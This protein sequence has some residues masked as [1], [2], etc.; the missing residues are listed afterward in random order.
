[1]PLHENVIVAASSL[2][3][4]QGRTGGC[5]VLL[6][7]VAWVDGGQHGQLHRLSCCRPLH[8]SST[9]LQQARMQPECMAQA[10]ARKD[11]YVHMWMGRLQPAEAMH[12]NAKRARLIEIS[13]ACVI[14]MRSWAKT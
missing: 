10:E 6:N 3:V 2:G 5:G 1:M 13:A 8:A 9:E 4:L 14:L 12:G 11:A 7:G